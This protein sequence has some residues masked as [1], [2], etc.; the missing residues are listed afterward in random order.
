MKAKLVPIVLAVAVIWL[1][2][3]FV[4]LFAPDFIS[5]SQH[6]HLKLAAGVTWIWGAAATISFLK[7]IPRHLAKN[8]EQSQIFTGIAVSVVVIWVA[9]TLVSIFVPPMVTGTDPTV[10]PFAAM[11]APIGGAITTW[12][13]EHLVERIYL[14]PGDTGMVAGD[15]RSES[16][17]AFCPKCGSKVMVDSDYCARCGSKLVGA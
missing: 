1:G 17:V 13:V 16:E 11:L 6:D 7:M 12:M 2:V 3:L 8:K 5:G 4:S 10:L 14:M 15:V 9:V